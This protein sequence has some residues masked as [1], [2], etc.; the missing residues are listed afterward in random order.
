M[1]TALASL[2]RSALSRHPHGLRGL[3]TA[4]LL[5]TCSTVMADSLT[6]LETGTLPALPGNGE[7]TRLLSVDQRIVAVDAQHAWTLDKLGKG[8]E[9]LQNTAE[10]SGDGLGESTHNS[11]GSFVLRGTAQGSTQVQSLALRGDRLISETTIA[12]PEPLRQAQITT[13]GDML[14][15][16]GSNA[17]GQAR[18]LR[19]KANERSAAWQSHTLWPDHQAVLALQGQ[20]AALY[21]VLA[22]SGGQQQ[23][24]RWM[25]EQEWTLL[26]GLEGELVPGSLRA[27]GQAHLLMQVRNADGQVQL[28]SFHTITS[29][30]DTRKEL[31]IESPG[32]VV[33]HGDGLAWVNADGSVEQAQIRGGKHL[34]RTLDWVVIAV[35]LAAMLC[36]GFWFYFRDQNENTSDFFVGGR[37]IPFWAAGISLYATNTSSISFIAIP[38]KAF[39]TNWQYMTNNLMAVVGLVFVAI[40][41]VPLLRRLDLMSVFS[42]LETRFHPAI[43]ML[44]SALC[45]IMQIGARMS[46]ILFLPALAIST[47]TGLDVIWSILMMGV[48]TIIYSTVGGSKAVIWTDVIQVLVMFGGALFAV[49][50]IFLQSGAD[51]PQ[52]MAAAATENKTQLFDFSFDLTKATV[53]GFIFLV[54]FDVV[55]T[56]PKD[57]VLM[58]RTLSTKSDKEAG[59]SIWAFAAIMIPGGFVFYGI[60]TALWMYYKNNPERMNPL[61]PVDA[62]FPLFI[63]AELPAGVTGL[64]IAGIFAAAMSTLSSIINSVGTLISVDFYQKLSKA[65][66]E[67]T[68]VRVAEWSGVGV[69]VIGIVIALVMSRY[70]IQSLFDVS[71]E[72]AGLLG[73]GFAGAY[74]LG[75][76]TRR[77]NSAGVAIGVAGS[78]IITMICWSMNLVHPYFYLA[79]SIV[80]CIVIGYVASL[81]FPPPSRSLDGLTIYSGSDSNSA[82]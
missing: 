35:Y 22:D 39:D 34:L 25:P 48:F 58:Q 52:L 53:W 37:S 68:A 49:G 31:R 26:P 67:K 54:V 72:L 4:L 8:W 44:S 29:A 59:R 9:P 46:V 30:W 16:A 36:M 80:L 45:I 77:A 17:Q 70:D 65:P 82:S 66:N 32:Q 6:S 55:L 57:Q 18:L 20:R 15:V 1:L 12:L 42:Y 27:L 63:A 33:P 14:Y 47:I 61:L 13:L 41:I 21:A 60:G 19:Q 2:L 78:I 51:L 10:V 11:A 76:F 5:L 3:A 73:G 74:T 43:R 28:R 24:W 75:M 23:L 69:G 62:T 50:F 64:I 56:F 7:Q 79:I 40:W 71:I 81:F 38:A